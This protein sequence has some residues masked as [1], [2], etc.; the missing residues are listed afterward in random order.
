MLHFVGVVVQ[1]PSNPLEY[2]LACYPKSV[3]E[4]LGIKTSKTLIAPPTNIKAYHP[5]FLGSRVDVPKLSNTSVAYILDGTEIIDYTHFSLA[6]HKTRRMAIWVAWNIGG[7]ALKKL[8]RSNIS[9]KN[10]PRIPDKHQAGESLYR[11]NDLDRGHI[12]RRADLIWGS[13]TEAKKAN[14]DSFFFTNIAPQM[15]DFNHSGLGGIWGKLEDAVFNDVD[16]ENLKISLIGGPVFNDDDRTYRSIK[17]PREFYKIIFYKVNGV[18]K[19]K[20]F[21][22]TQNIDSLEALELQAFKVYEVA[23]SELEQRCK[24]RFADSLKASIPEV[25]MEDTRRR[26]PIRSVEEIMW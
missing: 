4:K 23:L 18:L 17:I 3:F 9:F 14:T 19:S 10:D 16:V 7:G 5:E 13:L 21:L 25:M 11:S 2:A 8:S 6:V 26:Q 1:A 12:A 24:F 20:A 15:N 22:L